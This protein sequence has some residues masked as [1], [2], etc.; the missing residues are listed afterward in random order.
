MLKNGES[1]ILR[2]RNPIEIVVLLWKNWRDHEA[3]PA[4]GQ[5]FFEGKTIMG[6]TIKNKI[7]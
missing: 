1:K 3:C 5:G 7:K 6:K 4:A 2:K